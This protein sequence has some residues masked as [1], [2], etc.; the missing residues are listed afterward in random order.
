MSQNKEVTPHP[1]KCKIKRVL[2]F[3]DVA[4]RIE[5]YYWKVSDP[6]CGDLSLHF[7]W[8][9]ALIK[10][11]DH[12]EIWDHQEAQR[13]KLYSPKNEISDRFYPR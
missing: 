10:A 5:N 12:P 7:T 9:R 1:H 8:S 3:E 13:K 2:I 6:V 4:L 11:L